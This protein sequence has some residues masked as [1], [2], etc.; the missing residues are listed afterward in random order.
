MKPPAEDDVGVI[1]QLKSSKKR[2][3]QKWQHIGDE[4][5]DVVVRKKQKDP[6]QLEP[7]LRP[8]RS[9]DSEEKVS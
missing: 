8:A 3:A 9:E 5:D 4:E 6:P 1:D 2:R 7:L